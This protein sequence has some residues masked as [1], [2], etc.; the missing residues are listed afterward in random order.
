MF[1]AMDMYQHMDLYEHMD[2]MEHLQEVMAINQT[3]KNSR[4]VK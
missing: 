4:G 2:M 3:P 1:A